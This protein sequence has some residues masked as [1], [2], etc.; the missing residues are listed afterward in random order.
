MST[1]SSMKKQGSSSTGTTAKRT[2]SLAR[3]SKFDP[4]FSKFLLDLGNLFKGKHMGGKDMIKVGDEDIEMEKVFP[5]LDWDS[6][7]KCPKCDAEEEHHKVGW[8]EGGPTT[9]NGKRV[10]L[11]ED[12]EHLKRECKRCSYEWLMQTADVSARTEA[13]KEAAKAAEEAAQEE[14]DKK[15]VEEELD[16]IDGKKTAGHG[17]RIVKSGKK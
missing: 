1:D 7:T 14:A 8:V 4:I 12:F 3:P 11:P 5:I 6:S 16:S 17:S 10:D 13:A 9:V 15:E 2:S